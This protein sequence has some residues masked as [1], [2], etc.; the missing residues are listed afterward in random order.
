MSLK[1]YRLAVEGK[2]NATVIGRSYNTI[3]EALSDVKRVNEQRSREGL[4]LVTILKVSTNQGI[5]KHFQYVG[6]YEDD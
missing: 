5:Y 6:E 4:K 3:R 1:H 2:Q